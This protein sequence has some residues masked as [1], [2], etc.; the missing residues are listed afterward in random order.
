MK[1]GFGV[2]VALA[3]VL[4]AAAEI[5]TETVLY[6]DGDTVME[7]YLARPGGPDTVRP[8]VLVIHDWD[9]LGAY[10]KRRTRQLAE[11]G[12]VGFALDIYGRGIRPK[13][14]KASAAQAGRYRTN[15]PLLRRR[16]RA[17]LD[18]LLDTPGVDPGRVAAIGYCFGGGAAL[19]LA[20]SGAPV[21][22]TVSFHGNLD[23]PSPEDA[24]NI[25]G[26]VLVL[27]G[28]EDPHV[29]PEQLRAFREEMSAAGVDWI[30]VE[31][32]GAV[33]SFTNPGAGDDPSRGSAYDP[34]ADRRSWRA[35]QD[36]L[37]ERFGE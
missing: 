34:A 9:G 7:G 14:P 3:T 4:P 27:H 26:A 5:R 31:Y 24:R 36:F 32:G 2:I 6:Q 37:T 16:A 25:Q 13:D 21:V 18:R 17:G 8:A 12:Y 33:H 19:E 35:M 11:L 29:T 22:G 28:A 23:T 1:I 20:R 30:L 15:R 10:E